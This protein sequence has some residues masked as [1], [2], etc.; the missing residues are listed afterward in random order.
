MKWSEPDTFILGSS[1]PSHWGAAR[2]FVTGCFNIMNRISDIYHVSRYGNGKT[3]AVW[4][5][6]HSLLTLQIIPT[7]D[8]WQFMKVRSCKTGTQYTFSF[9]ELV[10]SVKYGSVVEFWWGSLQYREGQVTS[11]QQY[12][13]IK[14]SW[15][16]R[17]INC[18][19]AELNM[20]N[21]LNDI[22]IYIRRARPVWWFIKLEMFGRQCWTI[23]NKD[24]TRK[25]KTQN[26][27]QFRVPK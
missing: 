15:F 14:F 20:G 26:N 25:S 5:A 17:Y 9:P 1:S 4:S 16:S 19:E 22:H 11:Y 2:S 10:D 7:S 8:I 27:Q 18:F 23:E 12:N 13:T 24:E 6:A 21:M 3:F